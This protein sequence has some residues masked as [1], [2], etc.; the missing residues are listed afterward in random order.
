MDKLNEIRDAARKRYEEYYEQ[1]RRE[2]KERERE[3]LK[4]LENEIKKEEDH[5][6]IYRQFDEWDKLNCEQEEPIVTL[7]LYYSILD[8]YLMSLLKEY[9][10]MDELQQRVVKLVHF[11]NDLSLRDSNRFNL[12]EIREM[13]KIMD[14]I[15]RLSDIDISIEMMDT[16]HDEELSKTLHYD[17][18]HEVYEQKIENVVEE[19]DENIEENVEEKEDGREEA[20]EILP[21]VSLSSTRVGLR[22]P[23]M[24]AIAKTNGILSSGTKKELALR[25]AAKHLVQIV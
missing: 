4:K 6:Y 15:I 3:E 21:S 24:R 23:A 16:E 9:D 20:V 2:K 7:H 17:L 8:P 19:K 5:S 11:L 10:R 14:M 12:D 25:L 13:A 1:E 22:L 18:N